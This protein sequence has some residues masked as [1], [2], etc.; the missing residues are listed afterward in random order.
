MNKIINNSV[1]EIDYTLKDSNGNI[2]D[3]TKNR[4]PLAYIQG[5]NHL[6]P[7]L[8]KKLLGKNIGESCHIMLPPKDAY[9][10]I[11]H[12]IIKT[13]PKD[14]LGADK[15]KVQIGTQFQ[16][17]DKHGNYSIVTAVKI[18]DK[19][20]TL[21]GNHPLAGQTLYF[22]IDIVKIRKATNEEI[23]HGHVHIGDTCQQD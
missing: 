6:I 22:E 7:S 19:D 2:L 9:G 21:D 10:E 11:N 13:I 3:S 18:T 14:D 4:D 20:I 1:V 12:S 23:S 16:V 15:D 8:E 17:E 5:H